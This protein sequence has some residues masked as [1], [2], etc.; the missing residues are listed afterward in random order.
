MNIPFSTAAVL[1]NMKE[2]FS[3]NSFYGNW[4]IKKF[5]GKLKQITAILSGC[6]V[7]DLENQ[8]FKNRVLGPDWDNGEN[9]MTYRRLLQI[10]G[11]EALRNNVHDNV[12]VNALFADYKGSGML[13]GKGMV[14]E[15]PEIE[16]PSWIIT[17]TRFPN[18][19]EAVKSRGGIVIRVERNNSGCV[20]ENPKTI[21]QIQSFSHQHPS[22][23]AL[24]NYHF[25]YT[26][27]NDGTMEELIIQVQTI[28]K[29]EKII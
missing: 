7:D 12:W 4:H 18:E 24:D 28:L 20:S 25:D 8:E 3:G 19:A 2:N 14:A 13:R 22:E 5:A 21:S 11:T 27:F 16:Y 15:Q 29:Y 6:T 17:D 23:T 9:I 26:V 1:Y 10:V